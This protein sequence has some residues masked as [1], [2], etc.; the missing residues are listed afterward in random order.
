LAFETKARWSSLLNHSRRVAFI[1]LTIDG[2]NDAM[3]KIGGVPVFGRVFVNS[4]TLAEIMTSPEFKERG[5]EPY[6][7]YT[8]PPPY[9]AERSST[10]G[11]IW[12]M[13]IHLCEQMPDGFFA[14]ADE[15][16]E[17]RFVKNDPR[18]YKDWTINWTPEH[19][20]MFPTQ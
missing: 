16:Y 14:V 2:L 12:N 4:K 11:H 5:F 18:Y 19:E 7:P 20:M 3:I 15:S 8:P 1:M 10:R 6:S 17:P 13:A 9:E